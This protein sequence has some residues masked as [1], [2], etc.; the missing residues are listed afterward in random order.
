MLSNNVI[1][2]WGQ[3]PCFSKEKV[4]DFLELKIIARRLSGKSS[5]GILISEKLIVDRKIH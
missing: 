3:G 5:S 2:T 4:Y 1:K